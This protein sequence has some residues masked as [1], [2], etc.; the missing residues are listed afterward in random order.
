MDLG[1][2]IYISKQLQT[3]LGPVVARANEQRL[4]S[5]EFGECV[6]EGVT[7]PIRS[8][9]RELEAYFQGSLKTF[10]TPVCFV[11][12]SFQQRVWE[13]LR[14]ISFGETCSYRK[15]AVALG[16][17]TA[18]RAVAQANG[19]NRLVILVPCHR[20]INADGKLGGYSAGLEKK[21][22]LLEH[23]ARVLL[24]DPR[25]RQQTPG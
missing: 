2:K 17:P 10:E 7:E 24:L 21:K 12:T 25:L 13:E 16:K 8:I 11:G 3:P 4:Y 1:K 14:R 22:W 18:F 20:V 5:L 9:E 15:V 23:E 19:A 6:S